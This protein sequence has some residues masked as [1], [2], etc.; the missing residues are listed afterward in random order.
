MLPRRV[1]APLVVGGL[2]ATG[3]SAFLAVNTQ[4]ASGEG[5]SNGVVDGYAISNIHYTVD[6][7][8]PP[9]NSSVPPPLSVA[10]VSFTA[11]TTSAGELAASQAF[12]R[13]DPPPPAPRQP[14]TVCTVSPGGTSNS[15]NFTCSFNP[16]IPVNMQPQPGSGVGWI[17]N[18]EIEVNQ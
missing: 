2:L 17:N 10:S 5:V 12:V 15:T 6:P 11:T 16:G 7:P 9:N 13:L 14:W 8:P 3:G 1:L 18:L 4:P